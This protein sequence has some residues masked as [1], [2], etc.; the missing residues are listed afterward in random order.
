MRPSGR[1]VRYFHAI[2]SGLVPKGAIA[3]RIMSHSDPSMRKKTQL[4]LLLSPHICENKRQPVLAL[5]SSVE[6]DTL[7]KFRV[8]LRFGIANI[9]RVPESHVH[10]GLI[11]RMQPKK[12]YGPLLHKNDMLPPPECTEHISLATSGRLTAIRS[13]FLVSLSH[14]YGFGEIIDLTAVLWNS[15]DDSKNNEVLRT[16]GIHHAELPD[17]SNDVKMCKF[18][19]AHVSFDDVEIIKD[20]GERSMARATEQSFRR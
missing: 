5:G 19:D 7:V 18:Q 17:M 14:E 11:Q 2:S 15:V 4:S 10:I 8:T 13:K 1:P 12:S 20:E 9:I 3:S 6:Y 16:L